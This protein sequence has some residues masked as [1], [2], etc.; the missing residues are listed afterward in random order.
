MPAA[1]A[2]GMLLSASFCT[3]LQPQL[4]LEEFIWWLVYQ[5]A[6]QWTF[7]K[8]NGSLFRSQSM[9]KEVFAVVF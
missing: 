2:L 6:F 5:L 4:T 3:N 9:S 1:P 8:D 7:P